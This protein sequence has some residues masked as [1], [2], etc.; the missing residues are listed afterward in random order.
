[1]APRQPLPLRTVP[2]S[3][4][5]LRPPRSCP[6]LG[7]PG[8]LRFSAFL[9]SWVATDGCI[10]LGPFGVGPSLQLLTRPLASGP[11]QA[12]LF[13]VTRSLLVIGCCSLLLQP[14][15][16]RGRPLGS[17]GQAFTLMGCRA[18][19][20]WQMFLG[21]SLARPIVVRQSRR[22][23]LIWWLKLSRVYVRSALQWF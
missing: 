4:C 23:L 15:T 6:R 17:P 21:F 7:L 12:S 16:E 10:W 19:Q 1:M 14:M 9:P 8:G 11:V 13:Y 22:Q 3:H 5:L 18:E 2:S 20:Q